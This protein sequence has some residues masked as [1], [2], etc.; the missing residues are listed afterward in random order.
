[1]DVGKEG[2]RE[3]EEKKGGGSNIGK[4]RGKERYGGMDNAKKERLEDN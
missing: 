3:R 2:R 1:M 4:W